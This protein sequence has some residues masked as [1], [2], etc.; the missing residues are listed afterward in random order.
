MQD[1]QIIEQ[2]RYAE[3]S[4]AGGPFATLLAHRRRLMRRF[5]HPIWHC[6]NVINGCSRSWYRAGNCHAARQYR[7]VDTFRAG[8]SPPQRLRGFAGLYS[9]NYMLPAAGVR[10]AAITR[11]ANAILNA[12]VSHDA[13]FRVLQH[14]RIYLQQITALSLDWRYRQGE[15]LNRVVA[16]VDT[17]DHLY[18]RVISRRW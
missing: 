3:L 18:L 8:S 5:T 2:G 12:L 1:G 10:G 17:L 16:D 6:I 9:F 15:L 14:L 4:V 7:S 13:T 11:T